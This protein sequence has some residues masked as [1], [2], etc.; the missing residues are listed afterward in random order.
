M[1]SF[2]DNTQVSHNPLFISPD[3]LASSNSFK[4]GSSLNR[5][6]LTTSID[7]PYSNVPS[8]KINNPLY[9]IRSIS[10]LNGSR[11]I[12]PSMKGYHMLDAEDD[13]NDIDHDNN[14]ILKS[15]HYNRLEVLE[16][17]YTTY[18][19]TDNP[20]MGSPSVKD[21]LPPPLPP[22]RLLS[23]ESAKSLS[24]LVDDDSTV[25]SNPYETI[26]FVSKESDQPT[27]GHFNPYESLPDEDE[28]NDLYQEIN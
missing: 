14:D 17:P 4:K 8:R 27:V 7:N 26:P 24:N 9:S 6:P 23:D 20:Y 5:T 22:P 16:T 11:P 19:S 18:S 12:S 28:S 15:R 3:L 21:P 1:N 13:H 10:P 2:E 25:I